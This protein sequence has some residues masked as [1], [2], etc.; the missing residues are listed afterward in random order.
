LIVAGAKPHHFLVAQL[1][2]GILFMFFAFVSH[3]IYA[4]FFLSPGISLI[5]SVLLTCLLFSSALI[6]LIF[7][8][9]LSI[10]MRVVL[11]ALL[12]S[13]MLI[14][15][16]AFVS[17]MVW[18]FEGIPFTVQLIGYFLPFALPTKA[19]RNIFTK[20]SDLCDQS[21]QLAFLTQGIWIVVQLCLCFW[22][23]RKK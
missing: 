4:I 10:I 12:F 13:Q 11:G 14:Y 15:P 7:G 5:G 1:I 23:I 8:L 21:V 16:A 2:E 9:L 20:N 18:P 19:A 6:G 3:V 22:L 17:G